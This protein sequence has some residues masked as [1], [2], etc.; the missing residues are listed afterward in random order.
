MGWL[1]QS[2]TLVEIP[3]QALGLHLKLHR[4]GEKALRLLFDHHVYGVGNYVRVELPVTLQRCDELEVVVERER[5]SVGQLGAVARL[6]KMVGEDAEGKL[7]RAGTRVTP[8]E[9][10]RRVVAEVVPGSKKY[11]VD[12]H[13]CSLV[14][15]LSYVVA[16]TALIPLR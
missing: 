15:A 2:V 9:P 7:R 8:R 10:A 4:L 11:A 13:D 3:N 12:S 1:E 14:V 5:S 16:T 6:M